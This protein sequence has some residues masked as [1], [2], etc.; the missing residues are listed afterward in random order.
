MRRWI[1]VAVAIT[2]WAA[3]AAPAYAGTYPIRVRIRRQARFPF[4]LGYSPAVRVR[5]R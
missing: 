5:I 4:V 2:A 1:A 3:L